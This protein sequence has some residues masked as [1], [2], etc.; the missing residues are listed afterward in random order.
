MLPVVPAPSEGLL[1]QQTIH[2]PEVRYNANHILYL[3]W[4]SSIL[5]TSQVIS[6][7]VT[8][9]W[10]TDSYIS[11]SVYFICSH[12]Q[13]LSLDLS[14]L[15]RAFIVTASAATPLPALTR[16]RGAELQA[17]AS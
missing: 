3:M 5:H 13:N 9:D 17:P 7:Q 4:P 8:S 12:K 14:H 11:F 1:L 2:H 15:K 6:G 16:E 10:E